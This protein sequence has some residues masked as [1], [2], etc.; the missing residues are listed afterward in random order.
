MTKILLFT[1]IMLFYRSTTLIINLI[2]FNMDS[3]FKF[4][5]K[6]TVQVLLYKIKE[7]A[8]P[9]KKLNGNPRW[10]LDGTEDI[11]VMSLH[12][13]DKPENSTLITITDNSMEITTPHGYEYSVENHPDKD[14]ATVV[15]HGP[16][17]ALLQQELMPHMTYVRETLVAKNDYNSEYVSIGQFM[18]AR[19]ARRANNPHPQDQYGWKVNRYFNNELAPWLPDSWYHANQQRVR[20]KKERAGKTGKFAR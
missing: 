8:K 2:F 13:V 4:E 12:A 1:P 20:P 17:N 9:K 6:Q 7:G 19:A 18:Q 10:V 5:I 14:G 15:F 11:G 3:Y 16:V